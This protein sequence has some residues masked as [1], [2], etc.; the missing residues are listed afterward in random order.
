MEVSELCVGT[1]VFGSSCDESEA[2]RIVSAA[3]DRGANFLDTAE[4]YGQGECEALLG[5]V[6]KGRRDRVLIATKL[7]SGTPPE[8]IGKRLDES[9]QRLRTDYVDVYLLHWP[10]EG[11]EPRR[12]MS[13]LKDQVEA[14]K[15]R[16]IGCSNCPAWLVERFNAIAAIEGWTPM[17]CHQVPYNPIER[18][19]EVEVLPQAK[20][21]NVAIT[22]YRS[23][24]MGI[25]SGKYSKG[26]PPPPGSRAGLDRKKRLDDWLTRYADALEKFNARA[27][28]LNVTPAQLAI[29]WVRH[30]P[31]VTCTLVGFSSVRQVGPT[32]D[33]F[34]LELTDVQRAHVSEL[35]DAAVREEGGGNYPALRRNLD[36]V[37]GENGG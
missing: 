1:M 16:A 11:M 9:L 32:L 27:A 18:G 4:A 22:I 26:K 14:G 10:N 36:L 31:A 15:A 8:E 24:L 19:I 3:M 17:A 28:E 13:A 25:L 23:L 29:A 34:D 6:L 33:A 7:R 12:I 30:C 21:A 2:D 5:R 20:A 37:V 35:F